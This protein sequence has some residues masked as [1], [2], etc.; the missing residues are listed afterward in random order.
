MVREPSNNQSYLRDSRS[1]E[2][3]KIYYLMS[4]GCTELDYFERLKYTGVLRKKITLIV[5]LKS[6]FERD[7]SSADE[8]IKTAYDYV[9]FQCK[10]LCTLRKYITIEFS[11]FFEQN[12]KKLNEDY[13]KL[14]ENLQELR[15]E[16]IT[17]FKN[18]FGVIIEP[19]SN[20]HEIIAKILSSKYGIHFAMENTDS[21]YGNNQSNDSDKVC[22]IF[23]RDFHNYFFND[24]KYEYCLRE[25]RKNGFEPIVSSPKFELW[26][27]MHHKDTDFGNPSYDKEY[28]EYIMDELDK[29]EGKRNYDKKKI[30]K[31]RF[32]M[33]YRYEIQTAIDNSKDKRLFK[34]GADNLKNNP[35]TDVGNLL[36]EIVD[37]SKI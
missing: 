23:D 26:M 21:F 6:N 2:P 30:P 20:L 28:G 9:T 34:T 3:K 16:L 18:E 11:E 4:E 7:M 10:G 37:L 33:F 14:N 35:G 25:C 15:N 27:L 31:M 36:C 32:D 19:N 29:L 13:P 8:M 22:I 1:T 12:E 5:D 17:Q 24:K